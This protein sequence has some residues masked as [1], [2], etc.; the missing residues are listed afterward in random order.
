[1]E[2]KTLHEVCETFGVSRRAV[3][4]YEKAGLVSASGKNERG[5]LLYDKNSQERIQQIRMYQQMG[6]KVKE[7]SLLLDASD[8]QLKQVL[9][10]QIE[11][12]AGEKKQM[13]LL[14]KKAYE[15]IE[16]M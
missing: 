3:Q 5:H 10:S 6:F 13:E 16:T 14:I 4:G 7:I 1:M 9:E 15:L 2:E 11:K 8:Q 12:L